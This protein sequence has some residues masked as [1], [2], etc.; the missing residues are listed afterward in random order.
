MELEAYREF[1]RRAEDAGSVRELHQIAREAQTAY[2]NDPD[3]EAVERAC[4]MHAERIIAE[5]RHRNAARLA[6]AA[7]DDW[8]ERAA[9][10]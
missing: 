6:P 1:L 7:R 9:R 10:M 5:G 4:W 8:K 3:S 2:R